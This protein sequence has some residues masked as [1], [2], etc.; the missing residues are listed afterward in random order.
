LV[1]GWKRGFG[2]V[3]GVVS[4]GVSGSME[5]LLV[6]TPMQLVETSQTVLCCTKTKT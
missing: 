6:F 1:L 4:G 2:P 3:T 5:N